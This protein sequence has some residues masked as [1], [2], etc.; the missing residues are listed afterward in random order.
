MRPTRATTRTRTT[1]E[2]GTLP[3]VRR[4]KPGE[5]NYG[6]VDR[7]TFAHAAA[8]VGLALADASGPVALAVAIG[9]EVVEP[10]LKVKAPALFPYASRDSMTN[11]VVDVVAVMAGWYGTRKLSRGR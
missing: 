1:H 2:R 11:K 4:A 3:A 8:G 6:P 9:W 5:V 10:T 7:F